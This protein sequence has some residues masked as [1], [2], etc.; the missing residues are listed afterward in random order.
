[1]AFG[2]MTIC[3]HHLMPNESLAIILLHSLDFWVQIRNL[4]VGFMSTQV[5]KQFSDFVG[6]FIQYDETNNTSFGASYMRVKVQIDVSQPLKRWKNIFLSN[7]SSS[8]V[9]FKYERLGLF[10]FLC[11]KVGH[12]ERFCDFHF[13]MAID[14][15][16]RGWG[17][18][19]KASFRASSSGGGWLWDKKGEPIHSN[20]VIPKTSSVFP[21][22]LVPARQS[23]SSDLVT[24]D[25]RKALDNPVHHLQ[26]INSIP[27]TPKN[28]GLAHVQSS[29]NEN[30]EV[31]LQDD[32]K[33][34]REGVL[35]RALDSSGKA[36]F[37]TDDSPFGLDKDLSSI[38][39]LV[40][41]AEQACQQP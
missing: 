15:M 32:R 38:I 22:S 2:Y 7:G 8:Q 12:S 10:C 20:G 17:N 18:W 21:G 19:L 39:D 14:S 34:R 31:D 37:T 4:P 30:M 1:M 25:V 28:S 27:T 24:V 26:P 41:S 11:G 40:K 23:T 6:K 13:S 9:L 16:A 5:G 35:A 36:L 33:R 3:I 29:S